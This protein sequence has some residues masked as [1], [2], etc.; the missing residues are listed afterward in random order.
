[1][2]IKIDPKLTRAL[3]E[4]KGTNQPVQASF[5]LWAEGAPLIAPGEARAM[6]TRIVESAQDRA[7][8]K[9]AKIQTHE[10]LAAFSIEASAELVEQ[11]LN[12]SE[13]QTAALSK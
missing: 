10:N 6:V 5:T 13:I 9:L 8:N 2:A 1:M 11:I 3:R 12:A 7:Q 4:R